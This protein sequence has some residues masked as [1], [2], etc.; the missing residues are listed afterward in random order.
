[1]NAVGHSAIADAAVGGG[2]ALGYV[3]RA[4]RGEQVEQSRPMLPARPVGP[5]ELVGNAR[6]RRVTFRP[7]S[8]PRLDGVGRRGDSG[9]ERQGGSV[10]ARDFGCEM[11]CEEAL[12]PR[13]HGRASQRFGQR[14]FGLGIAY[15]KSRLR[16]SSGKSPAWR[17][18][19]GDA[20]KQRNQD[21][22]SS[23]PSPDQTGS[24]LG[25]REHDACFAHAGN[26]FRLFDRSREL[27]QIRSARPNA[28][29]PL[30][31]THSTKENDQQ[32]CYVAIADETLCFTGPAARGCAANPGHIFSAGVRSWR[33]AVMLGLGIHAA[34]WAIIRRPSPF[35]ARVEPRIKSVDVH[36]KTE[37]AASLI[38]GVASVP[39]ILMGQK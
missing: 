2:E 35:N 9:A 32:S 31:A 19:S 23:C 39:P 16:E 29:D 13:S 3:V 25:G 26:Y 17:S 24:A 4:Q 34:P 33:A 14:P 21:R 27:A 5:D 7:S 12:W 20:P 10:G 38:L 28:S 8:D 11:Q 30:G 37:S 22:G 36:D 6:Q 18:A 15:A 1:M